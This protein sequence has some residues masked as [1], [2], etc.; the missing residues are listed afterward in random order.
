MSFNETTPR[1]GW[2][3]GPDTRGTLSFLWS[4]TSTLLLCVLSALHMN[5]PRVGSTLRYRWWRKGKWVVVGMLA[6]DYLTMAALSEYLEVRNVS[7]EA[8]ECLHVGSL[9][10]PTPPHSQCIG[11]AVP[12]MVRSEFCYISD[13]PYLQSD[14]MLRLLMLEPNMFRTH[15][16]GLSTHGRLHT[17]I[18]LPQEASI[19]AH[20]P[21]RATIAPIR[22]FLLPL[23]LSI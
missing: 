13:T 2:Q 23:V 17:V 5:V 21:A 14:L 12:L 15:I 10:S 11:D 1:A 16:I 6:S 9:R 20:L 7:R 22:Q 4:C 3:P 18:T 8:K 19:S